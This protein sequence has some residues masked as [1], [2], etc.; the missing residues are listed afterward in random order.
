MMWALVPVKELAQSKQR[1]SGVLDPGEREGL[2]LAMLRDVLTAIRGANAFDGVL[3]VSRSRKAQAVAG[4]F[5][6]DTF[7]ESSGSDHSRAVTEANCYIIEQHG[8]KSSLAISGDIPRV[9]AKD[10]QQIIAGHD[11][12]TLVPNDS[13]EGTNAILTS[14]PNVIHCQFGGSSF[15]RHLKSAAAA[16]LPYSLNCNRNIAKDIDEPGDL[17]RAAESLLPSFT[18]EYLQD[19]GIA[20]RLK[21]QFPPTEIQTIQYGMPGE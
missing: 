12:V 15:K 9:T 1:L 10:I 11:R 5:V 6:T 17:I 2:V 16:G 8:A 18:R 3:L 20:D 7:M 4:E 14:P 13:G 19:S 21:Y